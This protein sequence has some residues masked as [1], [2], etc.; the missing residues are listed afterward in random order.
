MSANRCEN[1]HCSS[2]DVVAHCDDCHNFLCARCFD[3]CARVTV[4]CDDRQFSVPL[5]SACF[6]KRAVE[7]KKAEIAELLTDI[8]DEEE[9][10]C[11]IQSKLSRLE[12]K[13]Y[14]WE[15]RGKE[16]ETELRDYKTALARA[17]AELANLF[18]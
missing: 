12:E 18:D 4:A 17:Q 3:E 14:E 15:Q 9:E 1:H 8:K 2:T 6:K 10:L 11:R 16:S 5:C 13:Q 7:E